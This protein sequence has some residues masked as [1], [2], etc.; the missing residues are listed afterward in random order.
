MLEQKFSPLK[1]LA[2]QCWK[3]GGRGAQPCRE[4]VKLPGSTSAVQPAEFTLIRLDNL[5]CERQISMIE[6][7]A[8][9]PFF[10]PSMLKFKLET[11]L[12]ASF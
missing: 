7:Y 4:S 8:F 1:S 3:L 10:A 6:I 5:R 2:T 12:V 9:K 11:L